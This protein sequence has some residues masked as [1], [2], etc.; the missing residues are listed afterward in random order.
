MIKIEHERD[1]H[2]IKEKLD[3]GLICTP[4][5]SNEDQLV[6]ILKNKVSSKFIQGGKI[7]YSLA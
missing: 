7:I 2:L 5:A 6:D 1:R 3:N 4:Y